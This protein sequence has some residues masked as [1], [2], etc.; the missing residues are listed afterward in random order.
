M[1]DRLDD[2][3][4]REIQQ[5]LTMRTLEAPGYGWS[6]EFPRYEATQLKHHWRK[7]FAEYGEVWR[8]TGRLPLSDKRL[9]PRPLAWG[10]RICSR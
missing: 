6:G 1:I 5:W 8:R 10:Q 2:P 4:N 7:W 3:P 9:G